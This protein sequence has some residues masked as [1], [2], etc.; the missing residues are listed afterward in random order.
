M[1]G[2]KVGHYEVTAHLGS[3]GMGDVYQAADTKLGR[4]VAI[5]FLPEAF[6][7]DTERVARL[8]REARVLASLNHPNIAAI[9]GLE[10]IDAHHFLVMELVPGETLA[11]R[12]KRGVIPIEEALLIA[13]QI[14]EAL[15][16]AHEKGVIHRDLKPAN[17]KVTPDGKVK[18]LDFGLAKAYESG[19]ANVALSNSPTISIAAT[20]AGV[21][22]GT[23]A[24][25]SPEQASGKT[26]DKRT[27]LWA[28]GV[29]LLEMLT[30]RPV[31]EGETVSHV[32]ASVLKD[33][34]DWNA[35]PQGT[36]EP[37]HRLLGRCLEKDRKRRQDSAADARLEIEEAQ[38]APS[39]V[40]G[41]ANAGPHGGS[42]RAL[43]IA[44]AVAALAAVGMAIPAALHLREIPPEQRVIRTLIEPPPGTQ[45]DFSN[46][47]GLPVI[48]PNGKKIVFGARTSDGKNPLWVRSLDGLVAQPLAGTDGAAFP[49]WSPDIRF[50]AFFEDGRLQKIDAAGGPVLT[51]A[52]APNGRGGSW[53]RSGDIVFD[54]GGNSPTMM[55]VSSAGGVAAPILKERGS[56]PFFLPDGKHFLFQGNPVDV[57]RSVN[58]ASLDNASAKVLRTADTNAVYA[59]MNLLF[60]LHGTLMAQPFD[61][62]RLASN[63]EAVPIAEKVGATLGTGRASSVSV[64]DSG[65]LLY[66]QGLGESG[67]PLAWYGRDGKRL[68]QVASSATQAWVHLS[69]DQKKAVGSVVSPQGND[70][71]TYDL[72]R[73]LKTRLT[74][75]AS[76]GYPIWS[77]DGQRIYFRAQKKNHFDLYRKT[78]DG[79]G[80]EELIYSDSTDKFPTS[81]SPDDKTL[82]YNS[83]VGRG[84]TVMALPLLT[85]KPGEPPKPAQV[86]AGTNAIFSPDGRWIAYRSNEG[87][88]AEI[89]V[90]P[91]PAKP[92]KEGAKHQVSTNGGD[93][94][95]WRGREIFYLGPDGG[96]R[97]TEV[98]ET[99][100]S[101]DIG[102]EKVLPITPSSTV[103]GWF[104]DVSVDG[105]RF[106]LLDPQEKQ[107]QPLVLFQNWTAALKR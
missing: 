47:L 25:M 2:T 57:G 29:V 28:F 80:N 38:S 70:V 42:S 48:S 81:V 67:Y 71:W 27:D 94:P 104:G 91:F 49:F 85:E 8:Q 7:H 87:G 56:F 4:G 93:D 11:D 98:K 77:A 97:V 35:L 69:P 15:E 50:I 52:E 86:I 88:R 102:P 100:D 72:E 76:G 5:K 30:G 62:D 58:V 63:G 95:V 41:V 17:I 101:I 73:G 46:G 36:P 64:A 59:E 75:D 89:Y 54:P 105:Q 24:Y 82:L 6:S 68:T 84:P 65:L 53:S 103:A 55:R 40:T 79:S 83:N 16:E 18:V 1:I 33:E 44:L 14:A 31:F 96:V 9:H 74:F 78:A 99:G 37:I 12:L 51:L 61:P 90:T 23:A 39:A 22:L 10:E 107:G 32:L 60:I 3:G 45:F 21:I 92:G 34:P 13:K 19:Q 106:L 43:W 26:V 66:V 20:N